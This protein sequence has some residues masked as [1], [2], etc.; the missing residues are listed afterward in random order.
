MNVISSLRLRKSFQVV[1][2]SCLRRSRKRMSEEESTSVCCSGFLD[3]LVKIWGKGT[4]MMGRIFPSISSRRSLAIFRNVWPIL[5]LV[6]SFMVVKVQLL[7]FELN[8]YIPVS[9]VT[10][11]NF[12]VQRGEDIRKA[13]AKLPADRPVK[14]QGSDGVSYPTVKSQPIPNHYTWEFKDDIAY[15]EFRLANFAHGN[16]PFLFHWF[17]DLIANSSSLAH[18]TTAITLD[19]PKNIQPPEALTGVKS[20]LILTSGCSDIRWV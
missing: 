8:T 11:D 13:L 19:T 6:T 18:Q 3:H 9:A 17:H 4:C 20:I 14:I 12:S 5:L 10:P 1:Y 15:T 16:M 2:P 7:I